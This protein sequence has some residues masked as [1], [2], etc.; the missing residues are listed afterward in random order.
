MIIDAAFSPRAF[1]IFSDPSQ[2]FEP[3]ARK[4]LYLSGLESGSHLMRGRVSSGR[5]VYVMVEVT[6]RELD[7]RTLVAL[8]LVKRGVNVVIGDKDT[9]LWSAVLG[10]CPSGVI[11]DKCARI[12]R[13]RYWKNLMERGFVFSSLD[14]E[15]LVSDEDCFLEERFDERAAVESAVTFCWGARQRDMIS[16]Q[17][18]SANLLI[19]GNPRMSLLHDEFSF[20]FEE[21]MREIISLHGEFV[22]IVSS[23]DPHPSTYA[24]VNSWLKEV[25]ADSRLRVMNLAGKL[26]RAGIHVVYRPHPADEPA[27]QMEFTVDGRFN[28]SPWIKSCSLLINAKCTTSFEAYVAG[29]PCLTFP[30]RT[31]KYS[32]RFSNLFARKVKVDDSIDELLGSKPRRHPLLDR[33]ATANCAYT[34]EPVRAI[35]TIADELARLTFPTPGK[36]RLWQLVRL[37]R[38]RN[39]L[40]YRLYRSDHATIARKFSLEDFNRVARKICALPICSSKRG[41][42]LVLSKS[43]MGAHGA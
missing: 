6:K 2:A 4:E 9:L 17:Y 40:K 26:R 41:R 32:V 24:S 22:L 19:S 23:F 10:L 1:R 31:R 36:P 42:V 20:W 12:T 33:V 5:W 43:E 14:E 29:K 34:K 3:F 38:F 30:L 7:S 37:L 11:F 39:Q 15:G 28:V 18:P 21:E 35:S 25:D 16:R 13:S 27:E 8:E